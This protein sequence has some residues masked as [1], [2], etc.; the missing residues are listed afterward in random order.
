[1]KAMETDWTRAKLPKGQFRER[2]LDGSPAAQELYDRA[3]KHQSERAAL[4]AGLPSAP[5]KSDI[6]A[7]MRK[8]GLIK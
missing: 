4:K 1:L 2:V 7:E 6:E 8:R 5:S 3:S